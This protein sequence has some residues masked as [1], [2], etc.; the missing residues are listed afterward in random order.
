MEKR[1]IGGFIAAL[2][3]AN[4]MTQRELAERLHVSDKTVSRWERDDGAPDLALIPVIAEIFGVTC[5]ELLRGERRS[6]EARAVS[7]EE[8]E[9]TA[10]GEKQR[11]RLLA[12]TLSRFRARSY[13]SMGLAVGGLIAAMVGNFGFLRAYI[14][15]LAGALFWLAAVICQA[16]WINSAC[17][18]VEDDSLDSAETG[19][20]KWAVARRSEG[21]F[22]L[23][24]ALLAFSLPLVLLPGDT[25]V[26]LHAGSWFLPGIVCALVALLPVGAVC[27]AVNGSLLRRGTCVLREEEA[28]TWPHNH[29]LRKSCALALVGALAVTLL[30]HALGAETIWSA[31]ALAQGTVFNDYES[32][33]AFMEQDIPYEELN[34]QSGWFTTAEGTAPA[35]ESSTEI[36][37]GDAITWYD[38]EGNV[39]TEEEARTRTLKDKN[40]Q[41]V[42][43]YIDRN[44]SVSHISYSP[45]EGTVLPIR[46]VT[47]TD[48]QAGSRRSQLVT[49]AYCLLYPAEVLAAALVYGKKRAR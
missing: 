26:G 49:A 40:G 20:L 36:V 17:L 5:D 41:V 24:A 34:G 23:V 11:Q 6:P 35:P 4:G 19:R 42:C 15:F 28:R 2:R 9:P 8:P 30:G 47:R 21:V 7:A 27:W 38:A 33:V 48:Y 22:V 43:T 10:R 31:S 1:T 45:Q 29:V 25:Y 46:V 39:I 44:Q 12:A 14:G 3:R 18:S 32:F 13:V 16:V 37:G